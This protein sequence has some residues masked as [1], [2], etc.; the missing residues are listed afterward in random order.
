MMRGLAEMAYEFEEPFVL[1]TSKYSSTFGETA[2]PLSLAVNTTVAWYRS[3]EAGSEPSQA[4]PARG[5][6]DQDAGL[7]DGA[8]L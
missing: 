2:T 3:R 1:D 8:Y 6:V 7:R 4:P 5:S